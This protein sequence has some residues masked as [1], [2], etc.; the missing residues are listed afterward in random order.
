MPRKHFH[1]HNTSK[2]VRTRTLR[3]STPGNPKTSLLLAGGSIR[4]LRGRPYPVEHK[5]LKRLVPELL[6][7]EAR[8]FAKVT[9]LQ[10]RRV[11][12]NTLELV[13]PPKPALTEEPALTKEDEDTTKPAVALVVP[14]TSSEDGDTEEVATSETTTPPAP[15]EGTVEPADPAPLSSE[16]KAQGSAKKSPKKKKKNK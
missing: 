8:G 14:G 3:R 5:A 13:K 1:I 6:K 4:V 11:D 16:P 2:D 10:G 9:N 15:A 7:H 12:L